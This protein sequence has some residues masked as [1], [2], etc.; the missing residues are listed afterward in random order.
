MNIKEKNGKE[1]QK[2]LNSF[3]HGDPI[4]VRSR[5]EWIFE[6]CESEFD[7]RS[8]T[9]EMC[10]FTRY[11]GDPLFDPLM[12]IRLMLD[13][14]GN[15]TEAIPLYYQSK[16]LF[17]NEEIYS[18]GNPSCYDPK[19]YKKSNE[20]DSRLSEWIQMLKV[21]GYLTNGDRIDMMCRITDKHA[22]M[23]VA[24]HIPG[25]IGLPTYLQDFHGPRIMFD[26]GARETDNL[27]DAPVYE[28][29]I[30]G[31]KNLITRT[32]M[33][34][35]NCPNA[36]DPERLKVIT[37][38]INAHLAIL[39]LTWFCKVDD[40]DL[41]QYF[42]GRIPFSKLLDSIDVSPEHKDQIIKCNSEEELHETCKTLG[43]YK[44][45]HEPVDYFSL[46]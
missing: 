3:G 25:F 6:I 24:G 32:W 22:D 36:F 11:N 12:R 17:Y 20:L 42:E 40:A 39:L 28:Y 16:T 30:D 37:D 1:I 15:V 7:E 19:L 31:P 8:L 18:E 10:L 4:I 34:E 14:A 13:R 5:S 44:L 21:Q 41:Q 26:G 2:I 9:I 23:T 29:G 46:L 43:L 27:F 45:D 38:F 35:T 33:D